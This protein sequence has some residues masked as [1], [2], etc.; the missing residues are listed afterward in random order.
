MESVTLV[1]GVVYRHLHRPHRVG[2]LA[3]PDCHGSQVRFHSYRTHPVEHPDPDLPCCLV[4]TLA[5]YACDTPE[6]PR[7]YFTP[8]VDEV[9]PY[10]HTSHRLQEVTKDLYRSNKAALREV[11]GQM[12]E[13]WHTGTGKSSV[14]RWHRESLTRDYPRPERLAFSQVL[15]IDEVYDQVGGKKQPIFTC[16]DPIAGITV[17]VPVEKADAEQLAAAME[18]VRD[19]GADPK[20]IVSDLW[21]AYPEALQ[22]VWPRAERQLCWFHV[23]QW[24]THQ[25]AKLLKDYGQTLPEEQRKRL[26]KLRFRLLASSDKQGRFS[27][28]Q[29]AEL[30]EAWE[31]IAGTVVEEAIRLRN[32]LRAVVNGS[33]TRTEARGRFDRLRGSWPQR[34]RPWE[35]RPGEP[36]PEPKADETEGVEGLRRYLEAIMAFFVRHFEMMITYLGHPGVP[37]TNNDSERANRRY[38]A[39]A[40]P[41]YGWGSLTGLTAFLIA[42]Q[43]FDS[44]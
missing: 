28:K 34:F 35:W 44:S 7:K 4:V 6:C 29:R 26:N 5:K 21:A 41:R 19:L 2:P 10:A 20:V 3:C 18:Q 30:A 38:R 13:Q 32:D 8:S 31:L 22:Q 37:R 40:R 14:L 42:L 16:V 12:R 27:E 39:I 23:Q 9:A 11:E 24:V 43:G 25:L 36:L 15:C 1:D 33:T 17:R